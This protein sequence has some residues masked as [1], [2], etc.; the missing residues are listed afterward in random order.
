MWAAARHL[1][2][3]EKNHKNDFGAITMPYQRFWLDDGR[4]AP[5]IGNILFYKDCLSAEC[6]SHESTHAGIAYARMFNFLEL[7][8]MDKEEKVVFSISSILCQI[9]NEFSKANFYR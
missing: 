3:Q 9:V 2:K 8:T 7:E 6:V 4:R 1:S 5:K